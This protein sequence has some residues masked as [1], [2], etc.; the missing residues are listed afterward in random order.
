MAT[1]LFIGGTRPEAIKL[2]PVVS[3][4][5]KRGIFTALFCAT[6]QHH[7]LWSDAVGDLDLIPDFHL[8]VLKSGQDLSELGSKLL[9]AISECICRT[10]PAAVIVQGDTTTAMAGALA[11]YYNKIPVIHVEAGLR[12]GEIYSPYPEEGNRK[13]ISALAA[14]NFAPTERAAAALLS[15]GISKEKIYTVGNTAVDALCNILSKENTDFPHFLQPYILV[16]CHRRENYGQPLENIIFAIQELARTHQNFSFILP[17]HPNPVVQN[18]VYTNLGNIPN[19]LLI[20]PLGYREFVHTAKNAF[21]ILSDSGGVQEEAPTLNKPLLILRESTERP[22]ILE[23][24]AGKLVGS[25]SCLI[26]E[27]VTK[28]ITDKN[29][30]ATMVN[31]TNPFGDGTASSQICDVLESLLI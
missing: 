19:I 24:G 21:L 10:E 6:G 31:R 11:G 12:T 26:V 2:A 13:M 30:Y 17:V 15:E 25:K 1:I 5:K 7:E 9:M 27:E 18:T 8:D 23:C 20:K 28:L 14:V 16:T 22:E 4:M 29:Y 3:E